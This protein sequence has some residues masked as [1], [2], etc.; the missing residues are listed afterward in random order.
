MKNRVAFDNTEILLLFFQTYLRNLNSSH[1]RV[2]SAEILHCFL[3]FLS[4]WCASFS[5]RHFTLFIFGSQKCL[6]RITFNSLLLYIILTHR[7]ED[8]QP[9]AAKSR[10]LGLLFSLLLPPPSHW[11]CIVVE[12][13]INIHNFLFALRSTKTFFCQI[14]QL[15]VKDSVLYCNCL[16]LNVILITLRVRLCLINIILECL[17]P[18]LNA[19]LVLSKFKILNQLKFN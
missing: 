10:F 4:V 15:H 19:Q 6:G 8:S 7:A 12:N 2:V 18:L 13:F 11:P 14:F 17:A 3:V 16:F 9:H 5:F 1:D